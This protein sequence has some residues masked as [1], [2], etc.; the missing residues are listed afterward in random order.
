MALRKFTPERS[1][2]ARDECGYHSF[3]AQQAS[4]LGDPAAAAAHAA[5]AVVAKAVQRLDHGFSAGIS[6]VAAVAADHSTDASDIAEV[7]LA[8]A[9]LAGLDYARHASECDEEGHG[10]NLRISSS[11]GAMVM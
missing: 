3:A 4:D 8:A 10:F 7:A 2:P 5:M 11:P 1:K 9:P 6:K